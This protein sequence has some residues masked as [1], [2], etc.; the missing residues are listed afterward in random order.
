M[1]KDTS[2][3]QV[4]K[5]YDEIVSKEGH[6]YHREVVFPRLREWL[7]FDQGDAVLDLG[8]GQGVLAREL[9]QEVSYLGID[10]AKPL[11]E[12]AKIRSSHLFQVGDVTGSLSLSR[13]DFSHVFFI[14]SLQNMKRGDKAVKNGADHLRKGGKMIVILN[15]PCYRIPRQSSWG[16]DENK[17]LQYRRIDRYLSPLEVPIQ[18]HPSQKKDSAVTYSYHHPISTYVQWMVSEGLV[19]T[20]LEEWH[21]LKL[22]T[23]GKA[24]MENRSRKEFPLFL[25]LEAT[26]P[27]D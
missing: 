6:T 15:H 20:R 4:G 3:K 12:K 7:S 5:W 1:A 17:K 2:W 18:M 22:S 16:I 26:L 19:I 14:L 27:L 9:P 23:G 11:I 25:A 24:K 21:S 10:L 8:C 13:K